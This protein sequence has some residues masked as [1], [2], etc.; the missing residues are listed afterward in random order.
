MCSEKRD[1]LKCIQRRC[2]GF[3]TV[4]VGNDPT[5]FM[6]VFFQKD[7]GWRLWGVLL[8]STKLRHWEWI[9]LGERWWNDWWGAILA[10][11]HRDKLWVFGS[12][13]DLGERKVLAVVKCGFSFWGTHLAT[14][15]WFLKGLGQ[16]ALQVGLRPESP[17][18]FVAKQ[19]YR[20]D[21]PIT[22]L[23]WCLININ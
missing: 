21:V 9:L 15:L 23:G 13:L 14:A 20:L 22:L 2:C 5:N 8:P 11:K 12:S 3:S 6:F 19:V 4:W 1:P 7:L 18:P 17:N 10:E 16:V